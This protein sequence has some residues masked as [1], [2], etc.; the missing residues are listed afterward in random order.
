MSASLSAR[1]MATLTSIAKAS[2]MAV[3]A[4]IVVL[5]ASCALQSA[6]A[7]RT[8]TKLP[9]K[10]GIGGYWYNADNVTE[11]LSDTSV[12]V[13]GLVTQYMLNLDF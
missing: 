13:S 2:S 7:T 3:S 1:D 4:V 11:G 10:L 9:G 12:R 5:L 8:S 6:S